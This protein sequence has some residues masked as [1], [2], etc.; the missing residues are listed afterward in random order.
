MRL[1]RQIPP[2]PGA[3]SVNDG[4]GPRFHRVGI[5]TGDHTMLEVKLKREPH[6]PL[7]VS[8]QRQRAKRY[9]LPL[10]HPRQREKLSVGKGSQR[11]LYTCPPLMQ[12]KLTTT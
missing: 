11:S 8:Y 7:Q 12:G 2:S 5:S 10:E 1:L 3:H 6:L 4:D 9:H